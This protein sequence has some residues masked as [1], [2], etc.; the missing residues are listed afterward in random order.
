MNKIRYKIGADIGGTFTDVVLYG[1]DG[2]IRTSKVPSTPENYSV[3][4]LTGIKKLV[5]EAKINYADSKFLLRIED[6]DKIRSNKKY[7]DSIIYRNNY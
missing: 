3:A 4:I 6:T 1:S 5:E 7:L 2:S